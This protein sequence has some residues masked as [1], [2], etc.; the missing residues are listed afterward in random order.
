VT[1]QLCLTADDL[2]VEVASNNGQLLKC[3]K[4]RGVLTLGIEPAD[5]IATIARADGIE[6]IGEFFDSSVA[7]DVRAAYGPAKAVIGNNVLA[8]VDK[9]RDFLLGCRCLLAPDG[10]VIIEAPYLRDLLNN[11]EYDT[12]YH[13][14][15]CYFSVTSLMHLCDAVGLSLVKVEHVPVHGGSLRIYAGCQGSS[16]G[17]APEVLQLADEE[18]AIGMSTFATYEKFAA[19]VHKSRQE[20]LDLLSEIRRA[21]KSVAGYGAPAKG[22]TLLNFCGIDVGSLAFTVDKNPLKVGLYTPGTHIPVQP[23]SAV[24][25]KQPD[26]LLILAWNFADEIMQQ[27]AEYQQRGGRFIIPVPK[28][29]V[30]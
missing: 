1:Q 26:Y 10:L 2:V 18:R 12:V 13:E 3:F 14:H 20:L 15:L 19:D 5:N 27:Q 24:L 16:R 29:K 4:R 21:G 22:N 17:H 30:V 6:T 28:P 25:E 7:Q 11:L 9:T 8:H 23:V